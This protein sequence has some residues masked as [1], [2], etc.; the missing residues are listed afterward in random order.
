M[1]TLKSILAFGA[2]DPLNFLMSRAEVL[3][4]L[5]E[6]EGESVS[7]NT[8]Y[9]KR[10]G[11]QLKFNADQLVQLSW[12]PQDDLPRGFALTNDP[13]PCSTNIFQFVERCNRMGIVD[14]SVCK[15]LTLDRQVAIQTCSRVLVLFDLDT[16]GLSEIL[17]AADWSSG[18][19]K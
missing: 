5:G 15:R 8:V 6:P 9:E 7:N 14:V 16:R 12:R 2:I 19:I 1:P 13:L 10:G 11:V 4:R 18:I 17:L 3:A